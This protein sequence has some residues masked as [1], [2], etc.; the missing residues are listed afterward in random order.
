MTE[1]RIKP[2]EESDIDTILVVPRGLKSKACPFH[3]L[4][5]LDE[6]GEKRVNS[7]CYPVGKMRSEPW[8]ILPPLMEWYYKKRNP[9]YREL[10]PLRE[11]CVDGSVEAFEIVYPEWNSHVVIPVELDGS[12][13]KV[14]LEVAH[15][16]S[17]AIVYWHMDEEFIGTSSKRHQLAV[18]IDPGEHILT[19]V[20]MSG[21]RKQVKFEVLGR[22][23][24]N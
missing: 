19:V 3:M 14:V 13:G 20:D 21:N 8:F 10:P 9:S 24:A 17:D 6:M 1:L 2:I 22:S 16:Q 23:E 5:H 18:N 4:V 12:L 11:G 7:S 15:R